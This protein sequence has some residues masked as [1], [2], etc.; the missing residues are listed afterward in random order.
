MRK[1]FS[2]LV[3]KKIKKFNKKIRTPADKSCS[4]RALLLASQCIGVSKIKN[5]LES[6]DVL[7]C[8]SALKTIGIKIVKKKNIYFVWGNG[9][10]SFK[11]KK[12]IT[13]I[14]IGNSLTTGRL[15]AGLLSTYPS[16]FYLHGDKSA[17]SRDFT[18]VIE[19]LEK[20]GAFFSP[21]KKTLPL[22]IEG[23]TLPLAQK[24]I[25]N[26]GS[27]QIKSLI[28]LSALSTPGITTVEE[29]KKKV[30][31]NHTEIFL[32]K[33]GANIKIKKLKAVNLILLK[34]QKNLHSFNYT[35]GCDPSSSAF[36]IFL[37]L[38]VPESKIVLPGIICNDTRI[39][40]IRVLKKMNANIKIKN[41]K[42]DPSSGELIGTIIASSSKLK[43]VMVTK[44]VA[45][46]I[47]ELPLLFI[48]ASLAKGISVFKNCGELI[49]K[50]SNRLLEV[51]KILSQVGIK[52]KILKNNSMKIYG[53]NKLAPQ[54]KS[55]LVNCD[56]DH[57][58]SLL[59]CVYS[60]VTGIKTKIKNFE[61]VNTSFPGFI[62]LI[63]KNLG[64]KIEINKN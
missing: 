60:L 21:R 38:I 33:I 11:I 25:E 29:S 54:N 23:T 22:V 30:S 2:V 7:N 20:V 55:I 61:T 50:E 31:R 46:F 44:D 48:C 53:K 49:H 51:K 34:G 52:S 12:K 6:E 43:S 40:F 59:A 18:R 10:N 5:L 13:R 63:E 62:S 24:H 3:N 15:M 47:D 28:L 37:A 4:I 45:K 35:V 42:R 39:G 26:K 17:N 1:K 56:G 64:A 19:P 58:I 41:L 9:L 8:V 32:K 16:K 14:Y 27:S 36:L 57:R